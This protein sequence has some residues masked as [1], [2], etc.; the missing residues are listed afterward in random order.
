MVIVAMA[1]HS[2]MFLYREL[3]AKR[4]ETQALVS[5]MECTAQ[6]FEEVQEQNLRLLQQIKEKD[7]ANFKVSCFAGCHGYGD[8]I[9]QVISERIKASS[10]QKLLMEEKELLHSQISNLNQEKNRYIVRQWW[11]WS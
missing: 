3:V 1:T 7:D 6:A 8:G 5:E 4:Q 2:N 10:M 11:V 9:H